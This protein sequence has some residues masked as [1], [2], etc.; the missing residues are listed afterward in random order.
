M[1]ALWATLPLFRAFGVPVHAHTTWLLCFY[2]FMVWVGLEQQ[3]FIGAVIVGFILILASTSL[4]VHEFA[5]VFVARRYGCETSRILLLPFGCLAQIE[6]LP[7][8]SRE[9]WIALAGPLASAALGVLCFLALPLMPHRFGYGPRMVRSILSML[10]FFNLLVAVFNIVPCFPM[11]GGRILRSLLT[12]LIKRVSPRWAADA[13]ILAT[14]ISVRYVARPLALAF[15]V[16]T[17]L[18]THIWID[19]VLFILIILAG[20]AE[21]HLLRESGGPD[22][23]DSV[24]LRSQGLVREEGV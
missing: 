21:F 23:G 7:R 9:I 19:A 16:V 11:D 10:C 8:D 2:G 14:R 22:Q 18:Y 4:L 17:C 12:M 15:L 5:H 1:K 6:D 20:E 24:E 3:S 13:F